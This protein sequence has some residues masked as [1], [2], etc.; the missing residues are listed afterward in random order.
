MKAVVFTFQLW[1]IMML[2]NFCRSFW[3][4]IFYHE[5]IGSPGVFLRFRRNIISI[6]P[7]NIGDRLFTAE[8]WVMLPSLTS[9]STADSMFATD[10]LVIYCPISITIFILCISGSGIYTA[11]EWFANMSA[12]GQPLKYKCRQLRCFR[13]DFATFPKVLMPTRSKGASANI[14]YLFIGFCCYIYL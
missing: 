13:K 6:W 1:T 7:L 5:L 9:L 11:E 14:M 4:P 2:C 12:D 10:S 3:R 8:A